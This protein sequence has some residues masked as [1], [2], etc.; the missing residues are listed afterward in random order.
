MAVRPA[1]AKSGG[2]TG[3]GKKKSKK[4]GCELPYCYSGN[5]TVQDPSISSNTCDTIIAP[6]FMQLDTV[7]G[8]CKVSSVQR[9]VH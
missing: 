6:S 7:G 8:V 9:F 1:S 5:V 4:S 3:R 2:Q